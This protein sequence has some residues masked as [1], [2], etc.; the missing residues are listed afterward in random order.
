MQSPSRRSATSS[1]RADEAAPTA[2]GWMGPAARTLAA[3]GAA[4][5]LHRPRRRTGLAAYRAADG[6]AGNAVRDA[7]RLVTEI[8]QLVQEHDRAEQQLETVKN[9]RDVEKEVRGKI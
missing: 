1:P 8:G 6:Q 5:A 9:A 4:H 7:V 2:F 3:Q